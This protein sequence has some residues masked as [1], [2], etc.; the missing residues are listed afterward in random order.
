M[1]S[2]IYRQARHTIIWFGDEVTDREAEPSFTATKTF[3]RERK[4]K[5][6]MK[7]V[8]L[9]DTEKALEAQFGHMLHNQ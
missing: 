4:H 9:G 1:M 3:A 7:Y 2:D 8:E 5:F 6:G